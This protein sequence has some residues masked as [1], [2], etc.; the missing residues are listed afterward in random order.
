MGNEADLGVGQ[1]AKDQYQHLHDTLARARETCTDLQA[2]QRLRQEA[3]TVQ[4]VLTAMDQA[5]M[6]SRTSKFEE[7][8][9]QVDSVNSSMDK[10]KAEI[11]VIIQDV[12]IA[13]KVVGAI[14][15]AIAASAKLLS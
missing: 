14:D 13:E 7:V 15:S 6:A 4:A 10:L 11:A 12:G 1:T 5:D 2:R 9:V 8:A 3:E